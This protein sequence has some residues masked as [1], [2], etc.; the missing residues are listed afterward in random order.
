MML[1][2]ATT[3][4]TYW[5]APCEPAR[6]ACQA[7]DIQLAEWA[8]D[9]WSRA[10]NGGLR[11][12]KAARREDALLRFIWA[13]GLD[14]LY[15][16][17]R[18]IDVGGRR[19]A[20]IYVRPDLSGLGP[21]FASLG[22]EDRLFRDTI[23]YLTCVHES[24]HAI[25]LAHTSDFDD[26]MYSFQFGGDFREYFMRYRRKLRG[27]NNIRSESGIGKNDVERIRELYASDP[28]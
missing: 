17:A 20:E 24:G 21:D 12:E 22:A 15:G 5:V 25:G 3:V 4:L 26:I 19:G 27:R 10:S 9:A 7:D 13:G 8:L 14:G 1:L 16:E 6:S 2:A 18:P 23:V 28:Q 11:F